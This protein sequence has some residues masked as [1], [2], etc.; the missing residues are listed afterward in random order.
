[1]AAA[2]SRA[3]AIAGEPMPEYMRVSGC[4]VPRRV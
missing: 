3:L 1:L 4:G 2:I